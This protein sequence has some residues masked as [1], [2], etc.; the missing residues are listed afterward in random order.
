MAHAPG[1]G[2]GA[3]CDEPGALPRL[4][5]RRERVSHRF[6]TPPDEHG[7]GDQQQDA[8]CLGQ[9][10]QLRRVDE[11]HSEQHELPDEVDLSALSQLGRVDQLLKQL[12][13]RV[14]VAS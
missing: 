12:L 3:G 6:G 7:A 4:G 13:P 11:Q 8:P 2:E 10:P 9:R 1:E 5:Q 14:F